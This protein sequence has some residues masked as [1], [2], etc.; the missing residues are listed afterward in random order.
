MING[1]LPQK[2]L[3]LKALIIPKTFDSPCFASYVFSLIGV[4]L[5]FC[6]TLFNIFVVLLLLLLL[7]LLLFSEH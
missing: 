3:E 1:I 7:L 5:D 4:F 6:K 2:K